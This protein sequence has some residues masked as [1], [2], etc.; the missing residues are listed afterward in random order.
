MNLD[1]TFCSGLRCDR[2]DTCD[3]YTGYLENWLKLNPRY[4][5]R[6]I[7]IA[8]FADHEGKCGR[9]SRAED[10]CGDCGALMPYDPLLCVH[11]RVAC[12]RKE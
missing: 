2:K 11:R 7:S 1:R 6:P 4:Q 8:Q 12:R 9:Y 10:L 3:R 5:G